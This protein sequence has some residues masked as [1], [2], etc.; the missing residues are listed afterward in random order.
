MAL[1]TLFRPLRSPAIVAAG[2]VRQVRTVA[3]ASYNTQPHNEATNCLQVILPALKAVGWVHDEKEQPNVLAEQRNGTGKQI[4]DYLCFSAPDLK[5]P[6]MAIEAKRASEFDTCTDRKQ[7]AIMLKAVEFAESTG[8]PVACIT[9]GTTWRYWDVQ[10]KDWLK[11]NGNRV[12]PTVVL[13][14]DQLLEIVDV[15][16][17]DV[18]THHQLLS[19]PMPADLPD[20]IP[21]FKEAERQLRYHHH[22]QL[23]LLSRPQLMHYADLVHILHWLMCAQ[24]NESSCWT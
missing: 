4:I 22:H 1:A 23:L 15:N 19:A 8:A 7:K 2:R 11:V 20:L 3:V 24:E 10:K 16:G 13:S 9:D 6:L 18:G 14:L 5:T 21:I 12:D 17:N